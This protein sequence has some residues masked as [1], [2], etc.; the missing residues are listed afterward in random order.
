VISI[1]GWNR[2]GLIFQIL[3]E[4]ECRKHDIPIPNFERDW[5]IMISGF[6][7]D[8]YRDGKFT[9][10]LVGSNYITSSDHR[11]YPNNRNIICLNLQLINEIIAHFTRESC[12][13]KKL[14]KYRK[15]LIPEVF[16]VSYKTDK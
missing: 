1:Y 12:P 11:K 9:P 7:K 16:D 13:G 2:I 3:D 4:S 8:E 10:I 15:T 5:P 6:T 14:K